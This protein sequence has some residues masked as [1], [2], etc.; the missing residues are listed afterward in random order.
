MEPNDIFDLIKQAIKLRD[1]TM[2]LKISTVKSLLDI[3]ERNG[4][5]FDMF[6]LYAAEFA[7]DIAVAVRD[8]YSDFKKEKEH[9]DD[10]TDENDITNVEIDV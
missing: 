10:D 4:V 1:E 7:K 9:P 2:E 3:A 5:P 6:P 8:S